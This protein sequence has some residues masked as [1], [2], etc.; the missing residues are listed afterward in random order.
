MKYL[1]SAALL[2]ALVGQAACGEMEMSA[3]IHEVKTKHAQRLLAL[4]GVVSVGI[5]KDADGNPAVVVG[6]DGPRPENEA[7]IPDVLEGYPVV[8]QVI[9]AIK[10]QQ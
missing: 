10:A 1:L 7:E 2:F 6:L 3:T 8:T 9:G 4:P 5:G